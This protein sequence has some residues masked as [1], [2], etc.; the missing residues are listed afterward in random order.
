MEI[1][2]LNANLEKI[3]VVDNYTS[4]MWC[5][6]YYDIGALDLQIE[7]T[8]ETLSIFKQHYFITRDDDD[9]IFRIEALELDTDENGNDILIIGAVDCKEILNQRIIWDQINWGG[10]GTVENFIRQLI[11]R[12][13]LAP[14]TSGRVIHNFELKAAHGYTE[15]IEQ[16]VTYDQLGDKIME[17]CQAFGYGWKI[18]YE[19]GK[20]KFDL[21]KGTDHSIDQDDNIRLIFSPEYENLISSKYNED[22]SEYKNVALVA[23]E[24]EGTDRKKRTVGTASGIDR[25][26]MYVDAAG[27]STNNGEIDLVDY[28]NLLIAEGKEK[29]AEQAVTKSFEG[30]VD[31]NNYKYKS[32]YDLG[33][34]VTVRNQY[35]IA[36]NARITEI[37]ETWDDNGYSVDPKFEYF[38]PIEDE[39]EIDGALLT[40]NN[41]MMLTQSG[42]PLLAE[43][44]PASSEGVK[45]SELPEAETLYDGC[46][47]PIVQNG[48]TKKVQ[49]STLAEQLNQIDDTGASSST[50][51]SSSKID[52]EY[53]KKTE[54]VTVALPI[55][56]ITASGADLSND[57]FLLCNG[58]AVSR[59]DYAELFAKVGT[60]F[61]SGDG[62]TTFN[63]PDL[64]DK[65]VQGTGTNALGTVKNAGL[66][67]IT[68]RKYLGWGDSSGGGI[69]LDDTEKIGAFDIARS[70]SH[71]TSY[72]SPAQHSGTDYYN[73]LTFNANQSNSIYKD[74]C[75]TVQPPSVCLYYYI[76]STK[77]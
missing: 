34:I 25:Y 72:Y 10:G 56:S 3:A 41:R 45:I 47:F 36:A 75:N 43:S 62:S 21:F 52:L 30:E 33:D 63:V 58:Q 42:S 19:G 48:E 55:G 40:E 77:H 9:A 20:F 71:P 1:N 16:Q 54:A 67:N 44:A 69:I 76:K 22:M 61:G 14:S 73:T 64:R 70:S 32:D 65:F 18:T 74:D 35:G 29:L 49:K 38:E 8:P 28:Y 57:G 68:G 37:I 46:C 59:S 15:T 27:I 7:A 24:G 12:N 13:V 39:P 53:A 51:F 50:T 31:T 17:L 5:K 60:T 23:G 4:L 26:E 66:P 6:R 11:T 2:V